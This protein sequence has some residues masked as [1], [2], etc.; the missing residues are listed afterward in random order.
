[1]ASTFRFYICADRHIKADDKEEEKEKQ[2]ERERDAVFGI[3]A[4]GE[5]EADDARDGDQSEAPRA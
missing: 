1:M 5:A 2:L 4:D 3:K